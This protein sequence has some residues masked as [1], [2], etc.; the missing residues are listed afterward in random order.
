MWIMKYN[1]GDDEAVHREPIWRERANF[2][3]AAHLGTNEGKNQW[4]QIWSR[5]ISPYR[6]EICSIESF[7]ASV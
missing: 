2:I 6:F 4:E 3:V 1:I 7:T 5:Q